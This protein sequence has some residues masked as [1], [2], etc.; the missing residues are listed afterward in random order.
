MINDS[1]IATGN[2]EERKRLNLP[3]TEQ[4]RFNKELNR[5]INKYKTRNP[6]LYKH[7][8]SQI[9]SEPLP[10]PVYCL[11]KDHKD[12]ELKGRPIHSAT[13]TGRSRFHEII[14]SGRRMD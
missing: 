12:G 7:L 4:I 6:E 10:S 1:T 5:I 11:P 2:Y 14:K 3:R 9:C 8:K 13:D